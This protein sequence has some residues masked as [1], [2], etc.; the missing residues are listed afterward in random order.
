M[1]LLDFDI[2]HIPTTKIKS[3]YGMVDD[4]KFLLPDE[5]TLVYFFLTRG[6]A[7]IIILHTVGDPFPPP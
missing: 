2:C 7:S 5:T 3:T 1:L 4:A 6:L